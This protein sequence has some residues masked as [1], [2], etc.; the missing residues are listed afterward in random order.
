V[1]VDAELLTARRASMLLQTVGFESLSTDY[2]L[3]L[4]ERLFNRLSY[5]ERAVCKFPFAGQ[6]ALVA[7]APL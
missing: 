6:Y 5:I 3:Y 2:F 7:R 1:D 4:P